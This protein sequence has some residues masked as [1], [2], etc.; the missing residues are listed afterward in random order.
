MKHLHM[1][2]LCFYFLKLKWILETAEKSTCWVIYSFFIYNFFWLQWL[3]SS[4]WEDD[5]ERQTRNDVKEVVVAYLSHYPS[6]WLKGLK[7]AMKFLYQDSWSPGWRSKWRPSN[8]KQEWYQLKRDVSVI[9]V[10]E[11]WSKTQA[12]TRCEEQYFKQTWNQQNVTKN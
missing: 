1:D 11:V 10:V 7:I 8:M 12:S 2:L 4:E 5:S 3:F 9:L 6:I